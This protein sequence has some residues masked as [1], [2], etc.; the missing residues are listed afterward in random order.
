MEVTL[1]T[2]GDVENMTISREEEILYITIM[3]T[4]LT[5]TKA[6][7]TFNVDFKE[8]QKAIRAVKEE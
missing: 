6:K 8:F 7:C 1:K 2:K 3:L 5:T 4:K